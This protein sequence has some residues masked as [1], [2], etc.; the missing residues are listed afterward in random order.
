MFLWTTPHSDSR[1]L[2]HNRRFNC[3]VLTNQYHC[4]P[5]PLRKGCT[6]ICFGAR[7]SVFSEGALLLSEF[8]EFF[9]Q[10][11]LRGEFRAEKM[12]CGKQEHSLIDRHGMW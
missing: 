8:D 11:R 1:R 7:R 4:P 9:C 2:V 10:T 6:L 12:L 3:S 5:N